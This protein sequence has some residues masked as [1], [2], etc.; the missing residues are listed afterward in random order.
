MRLAYSVRTEADEQ[1]VWEINGIVLVGYSREKA[2]ERYQQVFGREILTISEK[3]P[4]ELEKTIM[5]MPPKGR[6]N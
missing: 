3:E 5:K 4:S 6:R 1:K 2:I